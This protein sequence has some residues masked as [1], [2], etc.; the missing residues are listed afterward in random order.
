MSE[1]EFRIKIVRILAEVENRLI[2]PSAEVKEV[3]PSKDEIKSAITELQSR[4]DAVAARMDK[5]E[6]R[7]R[8]IEDKIIGNNEAEKKK[9]EIKA[10]EHDLSIRETIDSLKRNNTRIIGVPEAEEREIG[11][12]G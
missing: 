11:V 6:Q 7:F 2:S 3:K 5:A 10:K 8:D 4:M 9:R 1:P 12:L